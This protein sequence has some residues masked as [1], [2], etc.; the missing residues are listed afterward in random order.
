MSAFKNLLASDIE[1]CLLGNNPTAPQP[2]PFSVF[3]SQQNNLFQAQKLVQNSLQQPN[4][5][6][7]TQNHT[8]QPQN[9]QH[10]AQNQAQISQNPQILQNQAQIQNQTK[11]SPI[12]T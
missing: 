9:H 1:S 12:Q 4:G 6:A 5:V 2:R 8:I 3:I 7:Q 11:I 10:I